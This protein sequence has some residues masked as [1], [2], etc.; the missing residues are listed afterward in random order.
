MR[1]NVFPE[2]NGPPGTHRR[3]TIGRVAN[4]LAIVAIAVPIVLRALAPPIRGECG[5]TLDNFALMAG[6]SFL[7]ARLAWIPLKA[8][9]DASERWLVAHDP[10]Y[11]TKP[12]PLDD[13]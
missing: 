8:L 7:A 13:L 4:D 10:G 12:P 5:T 1:S 2:P 11:S 3:W 6:L 9:N